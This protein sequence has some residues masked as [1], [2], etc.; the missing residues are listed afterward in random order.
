[1]KN[2]YSFLSNSF[3]QVVC[4]TL[5]MILLVACGHEPPS[6]SI[7]PDQKVFQ[8][9][10]GEFT[11]KIDILW[12]IDNSLSMENN[13]DKIKENFQAFISDFITKGYDFQIAVT[14]TEAWRAGFGANPEIAHYRDGEYDLHGSN[15]ANG[16]VLTSSG[17]RLITNSTPN[18]EEVFEINIVQGIKGT[19]DERPLQSLQQALTHE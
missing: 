7:L 9:E 19:G 16:T 17:V 5:T 3:Y 13:Q 6:F 8:Q 1:M 15:P 14:N 11:N 12:V 18:I 10:D 2:Q 4:V